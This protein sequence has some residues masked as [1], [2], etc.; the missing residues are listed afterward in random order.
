MT[1]NVLR[2]EIICLVLYEAFSFSYETTDSAWVLNWAFMERGTFIRVW[3]ILSSDQNMMHAPACATCRIAT[4]TTSTTLS[5]TAFYQFC[6]QATV[7]VTLWCFILNKIFKIIRCTKTELF[8]AQVYFVL[9]HQTFHLL[10]S[11]H[12]FRIRASIITI[13]DRRRLSFLIV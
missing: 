6:T 13:R 5:S 8:L 11:S 4:P 2:I 7:V 1:A 3:N 9:L 10:V 12:S